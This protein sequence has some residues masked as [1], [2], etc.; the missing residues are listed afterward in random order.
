MNYGG[1][2]EESRVCNCMDSGKVDKEPSID[3]SLHCVRG[4]N[5]PNSSGTPGDNCS[6][7]SGTPSDN[8]NCSCSGATNDSR[9]GC[10]KTVKHVFADSEN[11]KGLLGGTVLRGRIPLRNFVYTN[12]Q[13]AYQCVLTDIFVEKSLL[14]VWAYPVFMRHDFMN[15]FMIYLSYQYPLVKITVDDNLVITA[16]D[17]VEENEWKLTSTAITTLREYIGFQLVLPRT[18]D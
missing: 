12:F 15:T 17:A 3:I 7:S 2:D 10:C 18:S 16:V 4:G 14:Q 9:C 6:S 1:K 5:C 11:E 13:T 8:G